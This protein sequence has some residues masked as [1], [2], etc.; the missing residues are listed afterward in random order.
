MD[1][2]DEMTCFAPV[3]STCNMCFDEYIIKVPFNLSST[4]LGRNVLG[5]AMKVTD[6]PYNKTKVFAGSLQKIILLFS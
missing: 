6:L 1:D 2:T 3:P 5:I 4:T